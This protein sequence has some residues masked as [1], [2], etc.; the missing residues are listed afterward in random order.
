MDGS[1]SASPADEVFGITTPESSGA[2]GLVEP[3]IQAVVQELTVLIG[4]WL[5][6]VRRVAVEADVRVHPVV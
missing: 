1:L 3:F 5:V 6:I 4:E 2:I